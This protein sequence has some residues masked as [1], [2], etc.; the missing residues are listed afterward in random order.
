MWTFNLR[1]PTRVS[2]LQGQ[3][4][5]ICFISYILLCH[6][7]SFWIFLIFHLLN[8]IWNS[9]RFVVGVNCRTLMSDIETVFTSCHFLLKLGIFKTGFEN[10]LQMIEL[11]N[12]WHKNKRFCFTSEISQ[13]HYYL[14]MI[15]AFSSLITQTSKFFTSLVR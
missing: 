10:L 11:N 13:D 15:H 4:G 8:G 5:D 14:D 7:N 6:L 3:T 12:L 2:S 9:K 1:H